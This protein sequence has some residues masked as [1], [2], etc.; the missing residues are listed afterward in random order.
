MIFPCS[1]DFHCQ[2]N[3]IRYTLE[4]TMNALEG[5]TIV[6]QATTLGA[7]LLGDAYKYVLHIPLQETLTSFAQTSPLA[8]E[9]IDP[10]LSRLPDTKS[11]S[12]F[13]FIAGFLGIAITVSKISAR[14]L[15]RLQELFRSDSE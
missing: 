7:G 3:I 2:Y 13:A 5:V 11:I 4:Y 14:E 12:E 1:C 8:A 6:A 10:I 15:T 9:Y